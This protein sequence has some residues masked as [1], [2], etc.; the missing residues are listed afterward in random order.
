MISNRYKLADVN[1]A[2]ERMKNYEEIKP[3]IEL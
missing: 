1:T 3:V 2:M